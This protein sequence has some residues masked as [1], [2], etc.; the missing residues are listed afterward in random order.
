MDRL[1]IIEANMIKIQ[2][3]Q[4]KTDASMKAL[5]KSQAKTD[6][7]LE[8]TYA[9]IQALQESQAKTDAQLAKT[10][11]QLAKTDAQ[12][13]KTDAQLAKTDAQLAKTD[14]KLWSIGVNLGHTAEEYFY[15]ALVE[16]PV[17]G[18]ITFDTVDANIKSHTKTLQ[19]EF[20]IVMYNGDTIGLI[21]VK[22]K[23]HPSDLETLTTQKTKNF[24]LL[25]PDYKDYKIYVGIA[26]MSIPE[27]IAGQAQN[28]GIAVLRQKGEVTEINDTHIKAY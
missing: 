17:L 24:R 14:A 27:E 1:A 6:A 2:E 23:V 18:G 13:A 26:G 10:D 11:A 25:F 19:D 8:K 16:K 4:L 12:L 7:Q 3:A 21:E 20:D 15:Y 28:K 22:H 5:Q 9:S